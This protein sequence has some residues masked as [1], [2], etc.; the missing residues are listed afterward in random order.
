MISAGLE[1]IQSSL[2]PP[3]VS[4]IGDVINN[5]Y[6]RPKYLSSTQNYSTNPIMNGDI[7]IDTSAMVWKVIS[8]DPQP[9]D[10]ALNRYTVS[11][12]LIERG[13]GTSPVSPD[14]TTRYGLICTPNLKGFLNVAWDES[15]VGMIAFRKAMDYNFRN[16]E[17]ENIGTGSGSGVTRFIDLEDTP[18]SLGS[19]GQVLEI[20]GGQ[21][22]FNEP[23]VDT[24]EVDN[25][26]DSKVPDKFKI[27]DI[28]TIPPQSPE[29]GNSYIIDNSSTDPDWIGHREDI[30]TWNGSTWDY[31]SPYEGQFLFVENKN[32]FYVYRQTIIQNNNH[33]IQFSYVLNNSTPDENEVN[34]IIIDNVPVLN[35]MNFPPVNDP[36][37]LT[38]FYDG[39]TVVVGDNPIGVFTDNENTLAIYNSNTG[40][41]TF[42]DILRGS[43]IYDETN[44]DFIYYDVNGQWI[45]FIDKYGGSSSTQVTFLN[46]SDVGETNYSG[47]AGKAVVVN[48]GETGLEF[49]DII[50][51][52]STEFTITTTVGPNGTV[53]PSGTYSVPANSNISFSYY[54]NSNYEL[55]QIIINGTP[56]TPANPFV[57]NNVTLDLNIEV[58]FKLAGS[59]T[60]PTKNPNISS[61]SHKF[62][63]SGNPNMKNPNE[64]NRYYGHIMFIDNN[65][66]LWAKGRNDYGQLG[67][68]DTVDRDTFIEV[69]LDYNSFVPKEVYCFD[70]CTFLVYYSISHDLTKIFAC[71]R[72]NYGK[73]GINQSS[74]NT[75]SFFNI[76]DST[77]NHIFF[78]GDVSVKI[79]SSYTHTLIYC[80]DDTNKTKI[81]GCGLN[82]GLS[83]ADPTSGGFTPYCTTVKEITDTGF[84]SED[85]Y[86]I[87]IQASYACGYSSMHDID[88]HISYH[89]IL[90]Y[91]ITDTGRLY[92]LGYLNETYDEIKYNGVTTTL[93]STSDPIQLITDKRFKY[94]NGANTNIVLIDDND[95]PFSLRLKYVYKSYNGTT[96]FIQI[97]ATHV[98]SKI[99]GMSY[100]TNHIS[101]KEYYDFMHFTSFT[102]NGILYIGYKS[103]SSDINPVTEVGNV[104]DF[105]LCDTLTGYAFTISDFVRYCFVLNSNNEFYEVRYKYSGNTIVTNLIT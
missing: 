65:N 66:R 8:T 101:T 21:L 83:G 9:Y 16:Q 70:S 69:P 100:I 55:D 64:N 20:S 45:S 2:S 80:G 104:I 5:V 85:T 39:L 24:E 94:I 59:Q 56:R 40:T 76:C 43:I 44:D 28:S 78:N 23:D 30:A 97:S 88:D 68:G 71:G 50:G 12:E 22:I 57:F 96:N 92:Y 26:V 77:G 4:N 47:N 81:Y 67:L 54:P 31:S 27:I 19:D 3:F 34:E 7:I 75:S 11:L 42:K 105:S 52:S 79:S 36:S 84:D 1:I 17:L 29:I 91:F 37:T 49:S 90:S 48:Q 62:S 25:V 61:D 33:W 58:S 93:S 6:L 103:D 51:S 46:L 38:P 14:S 74:S 32:E 98:D 18:S 63:V 102:H 41:W 35:S 82:A 53:T 87:D 13:P 72:N 86:F 99:E 73:L 10:S 15:K 89:N 60:L 95:L